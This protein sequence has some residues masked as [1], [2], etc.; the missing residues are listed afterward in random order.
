MSGKPGFLGG[1]R[2]GGASDWGS[3]NGRD[4]DAQGNSGFRFA[5]TPRERPFATPPG[6]DPVWGTLGGPTAQ[7]IDPWAPVPVDD[8]PEG[9][10]LDVEVLGNGFQIAGRVYIGQFDRLSDWINNQ[11]GFVRVSEATQVSQRRD[12]TGDDQA[13]GTLWIRVDQIVMMA[14]RTNMQQPRV[15]VPVVQKQPRKVSIITPGYNL[16]GDL[17]IHVNGSMKQFLQMA[18][19]RFLPI[20]GLTVHWLDNQQLVARYPFAVVNR[21]QLLTILDEPVSPAG[22]SGQQED[23]S[24]REESRV[25]ASR[26]GAA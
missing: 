10:P 2:Q 17:H 7:T 13:R 20:T 8:A 15:G 26:W 12:G 19:P 14:E 5:E 16:R 4:Q 24:G 9:Q 6:F 21:E 1:L 18:E 23:D 11:S 22:A 25:G 3:E